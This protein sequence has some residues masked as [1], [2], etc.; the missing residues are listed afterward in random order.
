MD[1]DVISD[2]QISKCAGV[3]IIELLAF[4]ACCVY[5][6]FKLFRCSL[7]YSLA[8]ER[9]WVGRPLRIGRPKRFLLVMVG[10]HHSVER[11][12]RIS[13]TVTDH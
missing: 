2:S 3:S 4:F 7:P 9:L 5:S 12:G 1:E 11:F 6:P 13:N 10:R 8:N